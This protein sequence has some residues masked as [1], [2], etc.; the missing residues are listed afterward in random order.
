[1]KKK[2]KILIFGS[3]SIITK[4][5]IN[6][7]KKKINLH[8]INSKFIRS[9]LKKNVIKIIKEKKPHFIIN[10]LV[11]SDNNRIKR[12]INHAYKINVYFPYFLSTLSKK[13]N[14]YLIHFSSSSIFNGNKSLHP[15]TTKTKPVPSSL[16]AKLKHLSEKKIFKKKRVIL[17]RLSLLYSRYDN[18]NLIYKCY[19]NF[20]LNKK[21]YSFRNY[22]FTP[23]N[24]YDLINF[25][26]KKVINKPW[27]YSKKIIQFSENNHISRYEFLK[28]IEK[29]LKKK[30]LLH[31]NT[32]SKSNIQKN[33]S[34]RSNIKFNF[35]GIKNFILNV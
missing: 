15:Y 29:K 28:K 12:N 26:I 5:L 10:S 23:T 3:K 20:L 27:Y 30:N 11:V 7:K 33:I 21:V 19:K 22:F 35:L 16:Y 14:F 25:I 13:L 9:N 1:M 17:I 4:E 24:T 8:I 31:A 18:K 2:V 34:I 6:F 32:I